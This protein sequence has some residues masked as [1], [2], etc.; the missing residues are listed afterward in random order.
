MNLRFFLDMNVCGSFM[1]TGDG[2]GCGQ[3]WNIIIIAHKY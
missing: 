3:L 2:T 1:Q